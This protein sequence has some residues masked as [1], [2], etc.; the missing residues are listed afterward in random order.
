[1]TKWI[2]KLDKFDIQYH[3]HPSMKAQV[4]ANFIVKYTIP[5]NKPKDETDDTIKQTTTPKPDLRLTWVLHIDGASNAQDSGVGS[6]L[7][8]SKG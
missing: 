4:L 3:P 6:F 2:V 5:N 1:M 8:I 7:Q